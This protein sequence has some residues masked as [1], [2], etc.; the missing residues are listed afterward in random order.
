MKSRKFIVL[1][2]CVAMVCTSGSFVFAAEALETQAPA[3]TAEADENAVAE[4]VSDC[5]PVVEDD[6]VLAVEET[7]EDAVLEAA[8]ERVAGNIVVHYPP[9]LSTKLDT[10]V[11]VKYSDDFFKTDNKVYNKSLAK[12]LLAASMASYAYPVPYETISETPRDKNIRK[13]LEE[14]LKYIGYKSFKYDVK[15]DNSD[16]T[17]GYAFAYKE[18]DGE[19]VM[20]IAVRSS[21][22]G[23]EW[24]SNLRVTSGNDEHKG[25]G[26]TADAVYKDAAAYAKANGITKI[27]I[28]GYSRGAAIANV[29]AKRVADN[30]LVDSDNLYCYTFE[31]P[32]TTKKSVEVQGLY[33]VINSA[34]VVAQ[35]PFYFWG[36]RRYGQDEFYVVNKVSLKNYKKGM[37][38]TDKATKKRLSAL[39][40]KISGGKPDYDKKWS[41]SIPTQWSNDKALESISC[42]FGGNSN[43]FANGYEAKLQ[44]VG[45]LLG[46][47]TNLFPRKA[48]Q[49]QGVETIMSTIGLKPYLDANGVN[50]RSV[51]AQH[52]PEALLYWMDT[53]SPCKELKYKYISLSSAYKKCDIVIK[54][55]KGKKVAEINKGNYSKFIKKNASYSLEVNKDENGNLQILIPADDKYTLKLTAKSAVT[56]DYKVTDYNCYDVCG[57]ADYKGIKLKKKGTITAKASNNYA[58]KVSKGTAGTEEK[59]DINDVSVVTVSASVQGGSSFL[60]IP[61]DFVTGVGEYPDGYEVKLTLHL[62][63]SS[64]YVCESWELDGSVVGSGNKCTITTDASKSNKL[65]VKLKQKS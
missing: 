24:A 38:P 57:I 27:W 36:Y 40:S 56:V 29:L 13:L 47:E 37:Y 19:K 14:D 30:K 39:K 26:N 43:A 35:I 9:S 22:Y 51:F 5:E 53:V 34:D 64:K 48:N 42:V 20:A 58:A 11:T 10:T 2:I 45:G 28:T 17:S 33:N 44:S 3:E 1:L 49:G 50:A 32:T 59:Y 12:F 21:G 63:D 65:V 41:Y 31:T 62:A 52:T 23:S 54:D 6:A 18:I 16:D 25:F 60:G 55:S 7:E 4:E 8:G 15:L 46:G 61:T